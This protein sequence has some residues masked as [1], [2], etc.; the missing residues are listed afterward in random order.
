MA[1]RAFLKRFEHTSLVITSPKPE[2]VTVGL[3]L[4]LL[5]YAGVVLERKSVDSPWLMLGA[6][7]AM[8]VGLVGMYRLKLWGVA[9][10]LL[11]NLELAGLV[12]NN[13]IQ[14]RS[15]LDMGLIATAVAQLLISPPML[16][17]VVMV[18]AA[19]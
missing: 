14:I 4:A 18:D 3:Q 6:G 2:A 8:I 16:K 5:L 17:A 19:S 10:N 7:L 12:L 15:P 1:R 11:T 13:T 9:L